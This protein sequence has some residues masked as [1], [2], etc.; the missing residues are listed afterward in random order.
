ML[1]N[2]T[3]PTSTS[4]NKNTIKILLIDDTLMNFVLTKKFLEDNYPGKYELIYEMNGKKGSER[5]INDMKQ[6]IFYD[7]VLM[8]RE[9][10]EMDGQTT[11]NEIRKYEME[12]K[13]ELKKR[14]DFFTVN[15]NTE[16][17]AQYFNYII[18]FSTIEEPLKK[19][20]AMANKPIVSANMNRIIKDYFDD[21]DKIGLPSKRC[22]P[23]TVPSKDTPNTSNENLSSDGLPNEKSGD[24]REVS[25]NLDIAPQTFKSIRISLEQKSPS[26]PQS[27]L[28]NLNIGTLYL[29]RPSPVSNDKKSTP[30][31][32]SDNLASLG[33][34]HQVKN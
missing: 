23:K 11:V 5:L 30:S 26:P 1:S 13:E 18:T 29:D 21:A 14:R 19:T 3:L 32:V 9:M 20:Y 17:P 15:D 7:F 8:D 12:H 25:K 33:Y 4:E 31:P 24:K 10:P 6:G 34:Y 22:E 16:N 28:L 27:P 2:T